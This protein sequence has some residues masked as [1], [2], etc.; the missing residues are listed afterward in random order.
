M[1][2]DVRDFKPFIKGFVFFKPWKF[3]LSEC[4]ITG[5]T[6]TV[7]AQARIAKR[8]GLYSRRSRVSGRYGA[9]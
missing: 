7:L 1:I 9:P 2:N 6:Y 5:P 4:T 3:Q 8:L